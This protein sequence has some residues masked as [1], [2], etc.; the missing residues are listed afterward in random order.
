[1]YVATWIAY[2]QLGH[3]LTQNL[4]YFNSEEEAKSWF[5]KTCESKWNGYFL[6]GY[7]VFCK[8]SYI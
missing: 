4:A 2:I 8:K 6:N 1:M 5:E 3:N 7:Q